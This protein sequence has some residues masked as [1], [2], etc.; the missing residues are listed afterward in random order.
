MPDDAKAA[1][2]AAKAAADAA[3]SAAPATGIAGASAIGPDTRGKVSWG[4]RIRQ[5][6]RAVMLPAL[7]VF[8]ALL[9]GAVVI[10]ASDDEFTAK[11]PT[12]P[13]GALAAGIA[14]ALAAYR[15]AA[16]GIGAR[17]FGDVPTHVADSVTADLA[18]VLAQLER[19]GLNRVIFVDLARPGIPV[20]VVRVIVPGLEGPTDSP[21]YVPGRRARARLVSDASS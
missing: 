9:V 21:S 19:A 5:A 1:D 16:H 6:L 15:A 8:T 11:L 20:S 18:H 2:Q 14:S 17:S 10:I 12:D 13:I 3:E 4:Q 7:A